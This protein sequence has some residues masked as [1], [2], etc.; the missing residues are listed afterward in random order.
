MVGSWLP[1]KT[2]PPNGGPQERSCGCER[3]SCAFRRLSIGCSLVVVEISKD[4]VEESVRNNTWLVEN[5]SIFL[6][7]ES[8]C[9]QMVELHKAKSDTIE[10]V[11]LESKQEF[12]GL[13]K[14]SPCF[15][16]P[17]ILFLF[18][19]PVAYLRALESTTS[20]CTSISSSP[21]QRLL[22]GGAPPSRQAVRQ[23]DL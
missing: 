15:P 1:E 20:T 3:G 12:G 10:G 5:N 17:L 6:D 4:S 11:A 18:S 22:S 14:V 16:H 13:P 8:L 19:Q 9:E 21:D 23:C 2:R 7:G